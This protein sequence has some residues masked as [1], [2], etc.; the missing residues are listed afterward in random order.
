MQR[1][2]YGVLLSASDLMRLAGCAHATT[3]DLARVT[4]WGAAPAEDSE[5][6]QLLQRHGDAHEARHLARLRAAGRGVVEI[7]RPGVSLAPRRAP[8]GG[9]APRP[10]GPPRPHPLRPA[11]HGAPASETPHDP[12]PAHRRPASRQAVRPLPEDL[13]GRLREARHASIARLAAAARA[14]GAADILVAG[15]TFDARPF[16]RDPAPGAARDGDRPTSAGGSCPATTT[17]SPPANSGSGSS[18]TRRQRPAALLARAGRVAPGAV[19][20]PAPCTSAGR[21]ATSPPGMAGA[22]TPAGALRIG[23][24][25]GA[26][27][28]FSEDGNPALIPPDRAETAGLAFLALGDWHGQL[29]IGDAHL[30]RR[31]PQ[32]DGFKHAAA[33]APSS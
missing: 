20:L 15:D 7:V 14:H 3:L 28:S 18:A 8:A 23:L 25:H 11:G 30:V 5:D 13:R 33:P 21:A 1:N 16:A 6:A 26:V 29:A 32:A 12:L 10:E 2:E 9:R 4:G 22:A 24:A 17:A 31:R 19:L 27:Q